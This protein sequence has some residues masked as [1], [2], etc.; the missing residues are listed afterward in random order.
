MSLITIL[1]VSVSIPEGLD[2]WRSRECWE[3]SS[4]FSWV[5]KYKHWVKS[6]FCL[7]SNINE[8]EQHFPTFFSLSIRC[9]MTHWKPFLIWIWCWTKQI[10]KSKVKQIFHHTNNE[11]TVQTSIRTRVDQ[12]AVAEAGG[13]QTAKLN[14]ISYRMQCSGEIIFCIG[15]KFITVM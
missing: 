10:G 2:F 4:A 11:T 15:T 6:L 3:L 1:A 7:M 12:Q 8:K 14:E 13:A 5:D 9:R